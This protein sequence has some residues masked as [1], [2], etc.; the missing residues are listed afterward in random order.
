MLLSSF[1]RKKGKRG[2]GADVIAAV[3]WDFAHRRCGESW[4]FL[5]SGGEK[6]PEALVIER[7]GEKRSGKGE[8]LLCRLCRLPITD[9]QQALEVNGLHFHTFFNPAGLVFEIACFANAAGCR[10]EG[11]SS[12]H[13]SWFAGTSWQV[14]VCRRCASHLGWFFQ[15]RE[16]DF[17]G[18]IRK[19]LISG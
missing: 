7:P 12:T 10:R 19:Q 11:A 16:T 18:L 4:F 6:S 13:F 1:T 14:A 2:S 3:S 8:R 9:E 17:F 5:R 15:G